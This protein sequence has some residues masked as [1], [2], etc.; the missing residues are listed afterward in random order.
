MAHAVTRL[1]QKLKSYSE[2]PI[3][4]IQSNSCPGLGIQEQLLPVPA[5]QSD[6]DVKLQPLL[7]LLLHAYQEA[8]Q[9]HCRALIKQRLQYQQQ[10]IY[11]WEEAAHLTAQQQVQWFVDKQLHLLT[12]HL[13]ATLQW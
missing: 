1:E 4:E 13:K 11:G 8:V 7:V 6:H 10:T 12:H 3:A 9:E 2:Q 5:G